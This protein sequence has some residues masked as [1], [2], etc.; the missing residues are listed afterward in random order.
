MRGQEPPEPHEGPHHL[1]AH[2]DGL[3]RAQDRGGHERAVL[4]EHAG[5]VFS[6]LA[7]TF[8]K[9]AICD[10]KDSLS[11]LVRTKAKSSG[12][13]PTFRFTCSLSRFARRPLSPG[14]FGSNTVA[15][16]L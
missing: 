2:V 5:E 4:G 12:K 7:P 16:H 1:D 6:V 13:R 15:P 14:H 3:G 11:S 10:L 8:F 9:V